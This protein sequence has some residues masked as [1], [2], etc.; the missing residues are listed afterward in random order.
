MAYGKTTAAEID[1]KL[2]DDFRKRLQDYGVSAEATDPML[3]VLFRTF[4]TQ[5]DGLYSET[6]RIRLA[7]LDE[8]VAGLGIEGRAAR[9]AQTVV[10]FH[11]ASGTQFVDAG[12]E[13]IGEA[14]SG[15]RLTFAT[16]AAIA[17]SPASIALAAV[18]QNGSLQLLSAVEMSEDIQNAR[19]SLDPVRVNLGTNPAIFL[20]IDGVPANH[21]GQHGFFVQVSPYAR[22]VQ[23]ALRRET[24]C[25]AGYEGDF[26]ATGILRPHR[27]SAGVQ[28]LRWLLA[29]AA[30]EESEGSDTGAPKLPDGFYAGRLFI[31]PVVPPGRRFLCRAPRGM[32][33]AMGTIFGRNAPAVLD[34]KRA[35]LRIS[36]P[37]DVPDLATALTAV[38]LHA[39]SASNIECLN[40]TIAFEKHGTNIPVSVEAGTSKYL[41]APLSILGEGGG[42]YLPEL[43]P[44]FDPGAG[45][46]SIRNGRI[47][48]QPAQHQDGRVDAYA[49]L[50]LWVTNGPVGNGVGPGKVQSFLRSGSSPALRLT[51]PTSAAGGTDAETFAQAQAR[52]ASVLLSRERIVTRADV[53]AAVRAFDRRVQQ[54]DISSGLKR[55][56]HGLARLQRVKVGLAQSDFTDPEAESRILREEIESYLQQRFFYDMAIEVETEWAV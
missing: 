4:A 21:L 2:R 52:F 36:M 48:L 38:S 41:V 45:R 19:P 18:Y 33:P 3:A 49:N 11:S 34:R 44:S 30:R 32:E 8:L 35:W 9:A 51:N 17:V 43:E 10:R 12:T 27:A 7:L 42:S 50:R 22:G 47:H 54:V 26:G 6:E 16:D 37:R 25:L 53:T 28:M 14:Q 39:V 5:L 20:A 23:Q 46:Y 29:D 24:W 15:E 56:E 1:K 55:T 31:L 40:Q 13:L